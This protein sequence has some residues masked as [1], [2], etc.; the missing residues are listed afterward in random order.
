M[1]FELDRQLNECYKE[2]G[3]I[4]SEAYLSIELYYAFTEYNY[5]GY[6]TH[7]F[8][9]LRY[10]SPFGELYIY[11]DPRLKGSSCYIGPEPQLLDVLL[12]EKILLGADIEATYNW[13]PSLEDI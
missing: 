4:P 8:H 1:I 11:L 12:T 9:Q 10:I 3:F 2:L 6:P 5:T 13:R 7:G